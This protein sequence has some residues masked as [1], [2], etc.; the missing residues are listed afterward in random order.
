MVVCDSYLCPS[1]QVVDIRVVSLG[2][3]D[4]IIV[5]SRMVII[6]MTGTPIQG[7]IFFHQK[8]HTILTELS[9]RCM[10]LSR[11]VIL[12]PKKKVFSWH[13][14]LGMCRKNGSH[15]FQLVW[16]MDEPFA[17]PYLW[18][19]PWNLIWSKLWMVSSYIP[20][21]KVLSS[22]PSK[23]FS[24]KKVGL[25]QKLLAKWCA[26]FIFILFFLENRLWGMQIFF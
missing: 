23:H 3:P 6:M 8:K 1:Y 25:S 7:L 14:V 10:M 20:T 13:D 5:R 2:P 18:V 4:G 15:S 19:I 26:I 21:Q 11:D 12:A 24:H 22:T 16:S 9:R 17:P